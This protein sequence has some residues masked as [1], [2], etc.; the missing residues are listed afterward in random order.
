MGSTTSLFINKHSPDLTGK[1]SISVRVTFERIKKYYPTGIK[2]SIFDF[3]KI[4]G[5]K[6]RNEFKEIALKLQSFE[7][8]AADTIKNLPVFTFA[9]FEKQYHTNKGTK[10]T[11]NAAFT[12]YAGEYI[13]DELID[14]FNSSQ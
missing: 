1:C 11:I 10:D 6:P 3:E 12:D 14:V 4:Q 7:K 8:K 9:A 5:K 13:V 2:L